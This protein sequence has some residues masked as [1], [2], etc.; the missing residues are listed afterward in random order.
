MGTHKM[1][2]D[3]MLLNQTHQRVKENHDGMWERKGRQKN[4][5]KRFECMYIR[6]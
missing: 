6:D 2:T 5:K 1:N 4:I 3:Q